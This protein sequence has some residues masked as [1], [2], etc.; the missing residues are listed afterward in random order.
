M[1]YP[2]NTDRGGIPRLDTRYL[3]GGNENNVAFRDPEGPELKPT[4]G[5]YR[6]AT[7]R[8]GAN[9]KYPHEFIME[10]LKE[11]AGAAPMSKEQ[12]DARSDPE[13]DPTSVRIVQRYGRW[14]RALEL[15]GVPTN[16]PNRPSYERV[17]KDECITALQRAHAAQKAATGKDTPLAYDFYDGFARKNDLPS[18]GTI[19][20][21][22]ARKWSDALREANLEARKYST[23][24]G[25]D[26]DVPV[27]SD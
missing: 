10:R 3:G 24:H 19:R 25:V 20:N 18:A 15:A 27:E 9:Q 6:S 21:R 13:R 22:I 16:S 2:R 7:R 11:L 14:N 12:Y 1:N 23:E 26:F 17:S 8:A 4:S 5:N